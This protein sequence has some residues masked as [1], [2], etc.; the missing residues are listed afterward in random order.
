MDI[1]Y[2]NVKPWDMAAAQLIAREAGARFGHIHPLADG[3]KPELISTNLLL[4][5]PALFDD[6]QSLLRQADLDSG[7]VAS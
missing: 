1:Y 6:M 4:S 5:T 2:E 3:E 7:A